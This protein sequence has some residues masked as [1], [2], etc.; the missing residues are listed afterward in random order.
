VNPQMTT[1]WFYRR[2]FIQGIHISG[3][4]VI[5]SKSPINTTDLFFIVGGKARVIISAPTITLQR[6]KVSRLTR[7]R[8]G[9][10]FV[11]VC[12]PAPHST[13]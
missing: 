13:L 2:Y 11:C 8:L 9:S 1:D 10:Y 7:G 3:H 4:T 5:Y 6:S 12:V